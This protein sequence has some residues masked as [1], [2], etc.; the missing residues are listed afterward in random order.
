MTE[1]IGEAFRPI[2]K[3]AMAAWW[4]GD[5]KGV[6]PMN[7][8]QFKDKANIM[9][10]IDN[11][12]PMYDSN[13]IYRFKPVTKR[14]VLIGYDSGGGGWESKML[15]APETV[16]PQRDAAYF[17][18]SSSTEEAFDMVWD[19]DPIDTEF[20]TSGCVFLTPEDAQAM[21]DWL[22]V[23]RRGGA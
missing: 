8:W 18:S 12:E 15:V 10:D 21:S 4:A 16:A 11:Q 9:I 7:N 17:V 3:A 1:H 13:K 19:E 5:C 2:F 22:A 23:C 6:C 20:L 14:T